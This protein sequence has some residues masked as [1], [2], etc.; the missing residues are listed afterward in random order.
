[1]TVKLRRCK[2][3]Q[4]PFAI[5]RRGRPRLYCRPSHRVRAREKR[6]EAEHKLPSEKELRLLTEYLR[7]LARQRRIY[8][9]F[10]IVRMAPECANASF[11][12]RYE[13]AR[14]KVRD[15]LN[16]LAPE[17]F[18]Q[19][20]EQPSAPAE[21][22]LRETNKTYRRLAMEHHPDHGGASQTMQAVNQLWQ[23]LQTD[24]KRGRG[25]PRA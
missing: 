9:A 14:A 1:M 2:H 6:R 10:R 19:P 13:R 16:E 24:I 23:A 4:E 17:V 11:P 7:S 25:H 8:W 12:P 15:A 22:E 20:R 21:I 18:E 5:N 3:C